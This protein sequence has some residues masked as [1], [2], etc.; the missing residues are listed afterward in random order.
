VLKG[1]II[2]FSKR[3]FAEEHAGE[4]IAHSQYRPMPAHRRILPNRHFGPVSGLA[5]I[6]A[7]TFPWPSGHSGLLKAS[8]AYRCG[9]STGLV[10]F[11]RTG[12]P[13]HPMHGGMGHLKQGGI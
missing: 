2:V 6:E 3:I 13:F 11:E 7:F 5:R 1:R 12:F 9:G 8:R 4:G 10:R